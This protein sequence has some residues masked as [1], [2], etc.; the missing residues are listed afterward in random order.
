[1]NAREL[2]HLFSEWRELTEAEGRAIS[3]DNWPE[4]ARQQQRKNDLQPHLLRAK[5]ISETQPDYERRFRPLIA[6]LISLEM[7]NAHLL[8]A[9]RE[10]A[11]REFAE[12]DRTLG[13]LRG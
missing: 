12:C 6:Q 5:G 9:R 1:M 4:V 11:Q 8:T 2:E 13:N 3:G 10:N 7:P